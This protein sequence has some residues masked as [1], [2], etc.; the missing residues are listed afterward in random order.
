MEK[1][2]GRI[3]YTAVYMLSSDRGERA[4]CLLPELGTAQGKTRRA[5]GGCTVGAGK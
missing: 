2:T 1:K 4:W 3:L 5:L